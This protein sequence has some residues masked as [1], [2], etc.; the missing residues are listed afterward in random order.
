MTQYVP[1]RNIQV[2]ARIKEARQAAGM[3]ITKLAVALDV[4]PRTVARWQSDAA[5]PSV[6][7]LG[8]I[9]AVLGKTPGFFLEVDEPAGRAREE[10][11]A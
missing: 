11:R 1:L 8:H 4:D 3:S 9:A 7:R 2:G 6:E 5:S 10:T